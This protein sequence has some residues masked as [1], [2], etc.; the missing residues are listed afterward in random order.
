MQRRTQRW[1]LPRQQG[2]CMHR[3]GGPEI[4]DIRV[5][6]RSLMA[7]ISCSVGTLGGKLNIK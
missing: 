3:E 2:V 1:P 5:T 7:V 4:R 6:D